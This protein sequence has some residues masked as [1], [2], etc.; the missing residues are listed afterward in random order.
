MA[1]ITSGLIVKLDKLVKLVKTLNKKK[2]F[3]LE[4]YISSLKP[5]TNYEQ[6]QLVFNSLV[7]TI[8]PSK[9]TFFCQLSTKLIYSSTL[10]KKNILVNSQNFCQWKKNPVIPPLLVDNKFIT[11]FLEKANLFNNFFRELWQPVLTSSS[12]P[13]S[14]TNHTENRISV[15]IFDNEKIVK[16]NHLLDARKANG[17]MMV[18]MVSQ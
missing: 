4:R 8:R 13:K 2:Y 14:N 17:F 7:K 9:E 15:I 18:F 11:N 16:I 1:K 3:F 6:L 10:R 5:Q 12:F